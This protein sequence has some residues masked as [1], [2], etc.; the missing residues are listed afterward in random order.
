MPSGESGRATSLLINEKAV[1]ANELRIA[2]GSDKMKSTLLETAE[3]Q[4][5]ALVLAGRGYG[6]GVGM[7]QY[8]AQVMAK[9]GATAEEILLHYYTGVEIGK[10]GETFFG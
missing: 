9:E 10:V 6:H 1:P 5:G 8:G 4:D 3:L 2:L 7:S